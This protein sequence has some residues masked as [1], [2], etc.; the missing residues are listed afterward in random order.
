MRCRFACGPLDGSPARNHEHPK[1]S[2]SHPESEASPPA[3]GTVLT[4]NGAENDHRRCAV[5]RPTPR[6]PRNNAVSG[7]PD[8]ERSPPFAE[9]SESSLP[10]LSATRC[11][12]PSPLRLRASELDCGRFR[13]AY[14]GAR[15]P[16]R[17]DCWRRPVYP[18]GLDYPPQISTSRS[19]NSPY[20]AGTITGVRSRCL[21]AYHAGLL[22][23]TVR[24]YMAHNV[25]YALAQTRVH[26]PAMFPDLIP[27]EGP[28]PATLPAA[29]RTRTPAL[30]SSTG[31]GEAHAPVDVRLGRRFT[32]P[33]ALV[34]HRPP[35]R[36]CMAR[37]TLSPCD[38]RS[39]GALRFA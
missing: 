29:L 1:K 18:S 21:R 25:V 33:V 16:H 38:G 20:R 23:L 35:L 8:S 37:R 27:A 32:I 30:F 14:G 39:R 7:I 36:D 9:R 10:P 6:S 17:I 11:K 13:V 19:S 22:T 28:T 24:S 3:G 5:L 4:M 12:K 31:R 2:P 26:S 34:R 15:T